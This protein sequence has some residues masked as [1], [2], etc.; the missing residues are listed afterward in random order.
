MVAAALVLSYPWSRKPRTVVAMGGMKNWDRVLVSRYDV[1]S[2]LFFL[3]G[4]KAV[5]YGRGG[6]DHIQ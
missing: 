2:F 1:L 3:G 4:D 6:K 5:I